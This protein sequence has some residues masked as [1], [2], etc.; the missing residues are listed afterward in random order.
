MKYTRLG[1]LV[2]SAAI[3]FAACN[4]AATPSPSASSG[5]GGSSPAASAG[6]SAAAGSKGTLK[7]GTELPMSGGETANGVPTANGV[8]LAIA[9]Q[10][11]KGGVGG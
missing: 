3:A 7:I 8:K 4:S 5:G 6:G 9:Q 2:A 10:N 1:V 11:A